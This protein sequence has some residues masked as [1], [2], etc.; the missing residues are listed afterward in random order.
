[1]TDPADNRLEARN[2]MAWAIAVGGIGIVLFAALLLFAW[3]FA[4][5]LFLLFSGML[6]GVGLN[7]MTT[8]LGRLTGLPHALRLAIVCLALAGLLSGIVFLGGT[9]IAQ[10]ATVLSNT[11]KSQLG[12]VKEFLEQHGVDTSYLD[13]TNAA[14]EAKPEGTAVPTTTTTTTTP[15]TSQS[16][17][18]PGAGALA[19]SGGAIISQ[20]LKVLLGTVSVVG[21][22]FIVL[23]L[24]LAFAA[25]PSIYRA[26][27]LFIAPAKYRAQ[28]TVIV[29]RIGETLE[30]WLIAQIITMAAV[31]LVTWIGL[32]IIGI[33]SSFILGIQA[34]LLAFIPTVGA[35]LGGLI[36]VLASLATGWIAALSAFILFLGVHAL[37][38]YVLTPIIQRQALDIPPATLFA[39]QILLGVVFGIWGLALALPL[40]AIAKVMI[41]HFKAEDQAAAK[42]A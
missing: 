30:R 5:T 2:D 35:I 41:D 22:F 33:P 29:D 4:A 19:S 13:F 10:Q 38:S 23:F 17:G 16:H 1:M 28:A 27:L 37:E 20:T 39:F 26:G 9:T 3:Q 12:S 24:G 42:A 21:N 11:I 6:L 14:G 18:I 36:V 32:A 34:G 25:Q 15:A 7:A 8:L 40:M 31:F